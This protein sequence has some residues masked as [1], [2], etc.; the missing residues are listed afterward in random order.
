MGARFNIEPATLYKTLKAT[1]FKDASDDQMAALVIVANQYGLNPF[2]KEIYAFP[3]KGGGIVP[4]VSVDGWISLMNKNDLYD[5]IDFEAHDF[6]DGKPNAVTA[7]IH[8]KG[9][10]RPVRV[11][12]YWSECKRNTDP[13]NTCPRRMLRH[14]ALI[15]CARVAFGFSGIYDEDEGADQMKTVAGHEV[16]PIFS[17]PKALDAR[18]ESGPNALKPQEDPDPTPEPEPTPEA[19]GQPAAPQE[20]ALQT[21]ARLCSE[22]EVEESA[23]IAHLARTG[24]VR[25]EGQNRFTDLGEKKKTSIIADFAKIVAE[26]QGGEA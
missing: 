20:T 13:W 15:Q 25:P 5:G 10:S 3:A 22:F 24:V 9:R 23:V 8:I 26:M 1:V 2:T 16:K 18:P 4:V 6:E 19:Q 7:I 21:L 12:E 17:K 14:K 11:T